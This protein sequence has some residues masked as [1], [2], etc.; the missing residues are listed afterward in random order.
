MHKSIFQINFVISIMSVIV[1][2]NWVKD[3][4]SSPQVLPFSARA[5]DKQSSSIPPLVLTVY[6]VTNV[7]GDISLEFQGINSALWQ[8]QLQRDKNAFLTTGFRS[9][10]NSFLQTPT[11]RQIGAPESVGELKHHGVQLVMDE[12]ASSRHSYRQRRGRVTFYVVGDVHNLFCLIDGFFA[13]Q[14]MMRACGAVH[15]F[16]S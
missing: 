16:F 9:A 4:A 5:V 15:V 3:N 10:F 7:A 12:E 14:A 11:A 8:L 1:E 13:V 2:S 6:K